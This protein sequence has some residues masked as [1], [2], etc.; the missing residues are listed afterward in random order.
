MGQSLSHFS[1]F[2]AGAFVITFRRSLWEA[3]CVILGATEIQNERLSGPNFGIVSATRQF[4]ILNSLITKTKFFEVQ[5]CHPDTDYN[6]VILL[7]A[8]FQW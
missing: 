1:D 8:T 5:W 4:L 3:F 2:A 7:D 6:V